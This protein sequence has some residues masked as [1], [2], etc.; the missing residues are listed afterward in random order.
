MARRV[1]LTKI[2]K[3]ANCGINLYE[4][5]NARP[6]NMAMPCNIGGCPYESAAQ[7]R[8]LKLSDFSIPPA[9]RGVTYYE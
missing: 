5:T 6:H 8:A 3:C 7:Q 4:E 1:E 9:G 2:G